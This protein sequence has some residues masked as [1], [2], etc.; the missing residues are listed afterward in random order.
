MNSLIKNHIKEIEE[1][2]FTVIPSNKDY[3]ELIDCVLN[4]FYEFKNKNKDIV[5]KFQCKN[6]YLKRIVNL[7][8]KIYELQLLFEKNIIALNVLDYYFINTV[9]Y[10][11]LFFEKSSEQDMHRDTPYFCTKPEYKYMGFWIALEDTNEFNGT[12]KVVRGDHNL[13]ELDRIEIAK[14]FYDDINKINPY[15]IRLWEEYQ[16]R[17]KVQ[18]ENAGLNEEVIFLKKGDTVIWHAQTPHGAVN[19]KDQSK[20]RLSFVMHV[21][22][23]YTPVYQQDIFFSKKN[24]LL[25]PKWNHSKIKQREYINHNNISFEHKESFKLDEII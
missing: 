23:K 8:E 2:G 24:T 4:K 21:T 15:D 7:H 10:T 17:L 11:S 6:G 20:T 1:S 16:K 22:P 3:L 19:I 13:P 25:Q 5:K 12:L 14:M 9:I 18:Y